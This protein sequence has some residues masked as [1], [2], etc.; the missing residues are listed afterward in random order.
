MLSD[1]ALPGTPLYL[2]TLALARMFAEHCQAS[3]GLDGERKSDEAPVAWLLLDSW[4]D[5]PV[6]EAFALDFAEHAEARVAVP[7]PFFEGRAGSAPCL[8]PLP[9]AM[10]CAIPGSFAEAKA[11]QWLASHLAMAWLASRQRMVR[12]PLCGVLVSRAPGHAVAA[13]LLRLG[14]QMRGNEEA[15]R[16]FRYHDPRVMQRVWKHLSAAQ[17]SAWM[18]PIDNWWSLEQPWEPWDPDELIEGI[19]TTT[20]APAWQHVSKPQAVRA[21]P[22]MLFS[23]LLDDE[24]WSWADASPVASKVWQR[25][26]ADDVDM[27]LQPDGITMSSMVAQGIGAGLAGACLE[28]FVRES[29]LAR[30][31]SVPLNWDQPGLRERL[32]GI[33]QRLKSDPEA[34]FAGLLHESVLE[35]NIP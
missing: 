32:A 15:A 18:G 10:Q 35:R 25:L 4:Q 3:A 16:L 9:P 2:Q 20:A 34:S 28:A 24:Q 22:G 26:A 17:Q 27:A 29:W 31:G 23:R 1:L 33:L 11:Q 30:T 6:G 12:Q 8:V 19:P 5:N 7:D 13:H 14:F 21:A